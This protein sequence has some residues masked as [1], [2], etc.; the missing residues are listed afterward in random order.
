MFKPTNQHS[1][2]DALSR[3]SHQP[4]TQTGQPHEITLFNIGQIKTLLV[5]ACQV[6]RVTQNDAILS[7]VYLYVK[8]GWPSVVDKEIQPYFLLKEELSIEGNCVLR[9]IRVAV[10]KKLQNQVLNELHAT[11]PGIQQMKLVA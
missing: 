8:N 7:K 5:S 2:A 3:L 9:G 6:Q 11:H 4:P 10:P 1:N